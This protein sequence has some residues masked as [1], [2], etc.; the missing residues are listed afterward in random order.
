VN[1]P[2]PEQNRMNSELLP[3]EIDF[4]PYGG[5]L[6][7][8]NAWKNFGRLTLEQARQRFEENPL[9]YQE[10]FMFMGSRAFVYYFPVIEGFLLS[11]TECDEWDDRQAWILAHVIRQQLTNDTT[12]QV[13]KLAPR[14]RS[15]ANFVR[16]NIGLFAVVPDERQR[17]DDAWAELESELAK[18]RFE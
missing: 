2:L 15:L 5:D 3:T 11:T 7:A 17:I 12:G 9:H 6:D 13:T 8:L 18:F 10:D 1:V 4:D 14:M 16:S